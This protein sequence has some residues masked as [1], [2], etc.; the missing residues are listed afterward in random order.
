VNGRLAL[1]GSITVLLHAWWLFRQRPVACWCSF[2]LLQ[3]APPLAQFAWFFAFGLVR[4]NVRPYS[5]DNSFI[6]SKPGYPGSSG[7]LQ[8]HG[9]PNLSLNSDPAASGRVLPPWQF[10]L[11]APTSIPAAA[12]PVSFIR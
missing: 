2:A 10:H 7:R 4:L 1:S 5:V 9:V 3:L 11:T 12:G 8:F 6:R